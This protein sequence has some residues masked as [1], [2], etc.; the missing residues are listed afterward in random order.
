MSNMTINGKVYSAQD[1]LPA[2]AGSYVHAYTYYDDGVTVAHT[3]L[4][5]IPNSSDYNDGPD[6]S[7]MPYAKIWLSREGCK[8]T[9]GNWNE[10]EGTIRGPV[11]AE[12]RSP[13]IKYI[14]ADHWAEKLR[15][16]QQGQCLR[17]HCLRL[18]PRRHRN[19]EPA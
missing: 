5:E 18:E 14:S 13:L 8:S 2:G 4:A 15:D 3:I 10:C 6:V 9:A 11:W 7:D 17:G 16:R 1:S 19:L 12:V